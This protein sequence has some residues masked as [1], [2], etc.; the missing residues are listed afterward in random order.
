M[1]R[2]HSHYHGTVAQRA[3]S[4][5]RVGDTERDAAAAELSDHFALGRLDRDEFS[6]RLDTALGAR[7]RAD[8]ERVFADLPRGRP[9]RTPARRSGLAVPPMAAVIAVLLVAASVAA[10]ASGF[11]PFFLF[12]LLWV[13]RGHR[14]AWR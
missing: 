9:R 7:T 10:I 4:G 13:W 3:D 5:V 2:T 1:C 6:S 12:A 8:L 11:P 14:H